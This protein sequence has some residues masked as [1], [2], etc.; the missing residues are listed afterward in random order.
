MFRWLRKK[1]KYIDLTGKVIRH[2][3]ILEANTKPGNLPMWGV[4]KVINENKVIN[5]LSDA[6]NLTLESHN[7]R[8]IND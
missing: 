2:G 5:L 8:I 7:W 1:T 6:D 4:F 3:D